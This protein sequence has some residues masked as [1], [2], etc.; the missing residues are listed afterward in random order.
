MPVSVGPTLLLNSE[1]RDSTIDKVGRGE[2]LP[3]PSSDEAVLPSDTVGAVVSEGAPMEG[4]N[5]VVGLP[6]MVSVEVEVGEWEAGTGEPVPSTPKEGDTELEGEE[7]PPPPSLVLVPPFAVPLRPTLP[8]TL[9][10]PEPL[11]THVCVGGMLGVPPGLTDGP[12][13]P[14]AAAGPRDAVLSKGGE[15]VVEGVGSKAVKVAPPELLEDALCDGGAVSVATTA[16]A[17]GPSSKGVLLAPK[18]GVAR[19]EGLGLEL[20]PLDPLAAPLPEGVVPADPVAQEVVVTVEVNESPPQLPLGVAVLKL[21]EGE[22]PK[23]AVADTLPPPREALAAMV[24]EG[25]TLA[26][27]VPPPEMVREGLPEVDSVGPT[28]VRDTVGVGERE[29]EWEGDLL[30]PPR[31][32]P[33][34]DAEMVDDTVEEGVVKGEAL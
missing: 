18:E 34:L 11:P 10:L 20:L 22:G 3:P 26:L 17:V 25:A 2:G 16:E 8:E 29:G 32:P 1:E 13:L 14:V 27:P 28:P 19:F 31:P 6:A 12:T 4:V 23:L 9:A 33:P 7:L 15:G 24:I 21:N 5:L 30:L